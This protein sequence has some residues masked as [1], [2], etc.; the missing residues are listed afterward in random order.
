MIGEF[1]DL[2][3]Q[4]LGLAGGF[5]ALNSAQDAVNRL[6]QYQ[7][8]RTQIT[9]LI[10]GQKQWAETEQYLMAVSSEH[11]KVMT[12]MA[13]N[14]S[15][16]MSL[17]DAGLV[18][19]DESRLIFE[20]MSNVQSQ[21]GASTVQLGQ[22]MYGLS[23]ALASPIVRAEELN[24][25]VE[26]MPGLLN[27]L[28]AAA[29]LSA[30][31]FRRM[32]L[33][34]QITSDFFKQTL[35][36]ALE[37]YDGAAARTS[38]NINALLNQNTNAYNNMVLAF[39]QPI[40]D[41][42]TPMLEVTKGSL[43]LLGANAEHISTVVGVT[44]FTAMGRGAAAA[45]NYSAANVRVIHGEYQ[46]AK[47]VATTNAAIVAQTT[48]EI[49]R[50]EVMKASGSRLFLL[51][52]GEAKLTAL[53]GKHTTATNTLTA[54]Q[55]RLNVVSRI[56]TGLMATLGGPAGIAFMAAGA[57]SFFALS[58]SDAKRD[59]EGLKD[60]VDALLGR[61]NKLQASRL[62]EAI[63]K[64]VTEV[65]RLRQEYGKIALTPAPDQSLWQ[66]VTESNS[67][68]RERQKRE[69]T[70]SAKAVSKVAMELSEAER[71]LVALE[72]R[73]K[74]L[75]K[76]SLEP[77]K[78]PETPDDTDASKQANRLLANLTRQVSLYGETSEA[79]KVRYDIEHGA[80][81]GINATLAE[82]LILQA[83]LLDKKNAEKQNGKKK[84][85][86]IDDFY[87][88]SDELNNAWLMRLA[89]EADMENQAKIQEQ[90][91]YEARLG[92]LSQS[93]QDAY[94]QAIGNQALMDSL[95]QEYF[96][97][98]EVLRAQHELNLTQIEKEAA[99]VRAENQRAVAMQALS[100][101]EQQSSITTN[102]LRSA[103]K[104]QTGVYRALFAVQK[105]AAI[106][107]M[108]IATQEAYAKTLG[109]FPAPY[110]QIL[111][112]SVRAAGYASVGIV[113]GQAISGIAHAGIDRV[114]KDNEGTW[115][116]KANEMVL[117]PVQA[118]SFRWMVGMMQQMKAMQ[119]AAT[120][121]AAMST[122]SGGMP[123]T[124]NVMGVNKEQVSATAKVDNGNLEIDL[125]INEL[126]SRTKQSLISD[127]DNGGDFFTKLQGAL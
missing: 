104:E 6:G 69:A 59:T 83:Q 41:S 93:F 117:N 49:Q 119:M 100:F 80:L 95:E 11:N 126:V 19:L 102:F 27:K 40:S 7:D 57:L 20:G 123:V 52:N 44:L 85:D 78:P 88:E 82:Q 15:R 61:M 21:S 124:V 110:G 106:P 12:D 42:L 33:A 55:S 94:N 3:S 120:G 17:Y 47:A 71:D 72:Q 53:K 109:A 101:I 63:E 116:L 25:V 8:I 75:N 51:Q 74:S 121:A 64:Q 16:L 86:K 125:M 31:G 13:G 84:T 66:K 1:S 50:L 46:K 111:A 9:A 96:A 112:E 24:Q 34:G 107:S 67:E 62:E 81:K 4:V 39:E 98:R 105:A 23:Q 65:H 10:G 22:S 99:D 90:Y 29:G 43:E 122:R 5:L 2:K 92:N 127:V 73:L 48:S 79:A 54:A 68:M 32:M 26:P 58:A 103:G 118:D 70:E 108:I 113:A 97:N 77:P 38:E 56:G 18:T 36:T 35:I 87:A 60:E 28:D 89:M 115:L 14:Y 45:V 91:T 30:G 76:S 37:S 114:P